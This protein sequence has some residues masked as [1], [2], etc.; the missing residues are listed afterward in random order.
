MSDF[1]ATIH[2]QR[3]TSDFDLK[4]YDRTYTVRFNGGIEVQGSAAPEYMGKA[5]L[6]NPE[7]LFVSALSGCHMLTFLSLAARQGYVVDSYKDEAK[8]I[9]A[10]DAQGRMAITKVT[11]QPK[12]VFSGN[13]VP[14]AEDIAKLHHKAHE[15]CFIANSVTTVVEII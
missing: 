11:L 10:K 7:E 9:L 12:I 5:E 1:K 3:N 13:N 15:F 2:W 8:G 4:T 6:T 14:S